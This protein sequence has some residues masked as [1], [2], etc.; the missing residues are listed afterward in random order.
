MVDDSAIGRKV[1]FCEDN[2]LLIVVGVDSG[3][4][5]NGEGQVTLVHPSGVASYRRSVSFGCAIGLC[6]GDECLGAKHACGSGIDSPSN[7]SFG[8]CLNHAESHV[9][10]VVGR[11][12][13]PVDE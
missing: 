2:H 11:V 9:D 10:G 1:E 13:S 12:E 4:L 3:D 5:R 7:P 8:W 6:V